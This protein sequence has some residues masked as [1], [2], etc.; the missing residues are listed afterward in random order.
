MWFWVMEQVLCSLLRLAPLAMFWFPMAQ[1]GHLV[2]QGLPLLWL[3]QVLLY[4]A[5]LVL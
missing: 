3:V 2:E 5:Q 4:L 1:H